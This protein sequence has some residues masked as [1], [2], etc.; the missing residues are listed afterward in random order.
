MQAANTIRD[1]VA[2]VSAL[3]AI[4]AAQTGLLEATRAIKHFQAL[5]FAGTYAD[6][7]A[8]PTY[9]GAARFFLEELYSEKDYSQRDAQF[10]RIAGALQKFFPQQVVATA[11]V[12]AELHALTEELDHQM[13]L[14]WLAQVPQQVPTEGPMAKPAAQE[15]ARYVQA[16]RSV[17]RQVDRDLQLS[18]VLQV[19][20]ELDRLTR[21]PGLRMMLRL[22]RRPAEVAGLSALQ[23]FLESGFDTFASM[24]GKGVVAQQF[25]ATI[26]TRESAWLAKLYG[27]A[28]STCERDL[29][30]CLP[31]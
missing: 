11:V 27:A 8:S 25:L 24:A 29:A 15:I 12:M 30:A 23:T 7:L 16:W 13:A 1:A 19:G 3:R 21:T 22:M 2:R 31:K 5:R 10:S 17:E 9:A 18:V 28:P 20:S 14:A 26:H 6:L 4:A